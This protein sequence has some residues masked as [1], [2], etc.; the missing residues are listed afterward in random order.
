MRDLGWLLLAKDFYG[1]LLPSRQREA[2]ELRW[3]RD[4]TLGEAAAA[5]GVSRP[6]VADLL[7]RAEASLERYERA[8]GL[9]ER[10]RA[11]RADFDLLEKLTGELGGPEGREIRAVVRRLAER[12]G[13]NL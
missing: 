7:R 8:L 4:L 11:D 10:H 9:V 1:E 3:E 12:G 6:G 5:L 2:F 13:R